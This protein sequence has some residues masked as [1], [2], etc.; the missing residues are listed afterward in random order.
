ML[1]RLARV[2]ADTLSASRCEV[3]TIDSTARATHGFRL[4]ASA[5]TLPSSQSH[6]TDWPRQDASQFDPDVAHASLS[7]SG[8]LEPL[9]DGGSEARFSLGII[10]FVAANRETTAIDPAAFDAVRL[11]VAALREEVHARFPAEEIESFQQ[12]LRMRGEIDRRVARAFARVQS[13]EEIAATIDSFAEEL[14]PTE[15]SGLYFV[16]PDSGALRMYFGRGL[17]AEEVRAAESTALLRH[18]GYV[19]RTGTVVDTP[20]CGHESDPAS[21]VPQGHG[22]HVGSRLFIPVWA[23]GR[24]VGAIGFA[25]SR[26]HAFSARH[27]QVLSYLADFAGLAYTRFAAQRALARRGELLEAA[28]S[29]IERVL[30][31]VEWQAAAYA[32]LALLGVA[33]GSGAI[34]LLE[35]PTDGRVPAEYVWQ[36]NF[37]LPWLR[38]EGVRGIS[39]SLRTQLE[40][41]EGVDFDP[42]DGGP[43]LVL[44][45]VFG[46]D[47]LWGV[48]TV[49]SRRGEARAI[50]R[51]ER[52]AIRTLARA[53]GS[54]IARERG[55]L[56]HNRREKAEVVT[57]LA[58]SF[59]QDFNTELWPILLYSEML[60]RAEGFDARARHQIAEMRAAARRSSKLVEQLLS[61]SR[62]KDRVVEIVNVSELAIEVS[63]LL[64]IQASRAIEIETDIDA[65][66]GGVLGETV[67][68]RQSLL[69]LGRYGI[70]SIGDLAGSVRIAVL[71]AE[72]DGRD[73]VLVRLVHD[74]LAPMFDGSGRVLEPWPTAPA[75]DASGDPMLGL[76]VLQRT[77][78]DAGGTVR[79]TP[80]LSGG[81]MIEVLLPCSGKVTS[82][83][84]EASPAAA[85]GQE[86]VGGAPRVLVVDDDAAVLAMLREVLEAFGFEPIACSDASVA[87]DE[88]ARGCRPD[89]VLTDLTMPGMSGIELTAEIRR[90]GLVM[91]VICCTGFVEESTERAGIEAGMRA[92]VRKPVDWDQ[93]RTVLQDALGSTERAAR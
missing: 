23:D 90:R 92:F 74:G 37:G 38:S 39:A 17:T 26:A 5:G 53:F 45:P 85:D 78:A 35:L 22:R 62:S 2:V 9:P 54:A 4:A 77:V 49:E 34:A 60:E 59:A 25:N 21:G 20:D 46:D 28:N 83:S 68:L 71:Q 67:S 30:G 73:H 16:E 27:R 88:L 11:L 31:A 42:G 13:L 52:S 66:V 64:R 19:I 86:I 40:S 63:H 61:V 12:W 7:A 57:R 47:G 76:V 56:E 80:R 14:T 70:A 51:A 89:V 50:D 32:S 72:D 81:G 15:Y 87:L 79:I 58:S 36:P 18:P 91:P 69:E 55:M 43:L 3:W 29:A 65:D 93:L 24:V 75:N 48:L 10:G 82:E 33:L 84:R 1:N 6:P 44:K 41:D 8:A